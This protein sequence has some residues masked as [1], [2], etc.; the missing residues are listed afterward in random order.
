MLNSLAR[1]I[2][3]LLM[4]VRTMNPNCLSV[5]SA[6]GPS[7]AMSSRLSMIKFIPL[8]LRPGCR[9]LAFLG[10]LATLEDV[11]LFGGMAAEGWSAE[12]PG[13]PGLQTAGGRPLQSN[14]CW[15]AK[16]TR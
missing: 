13:C 14:V 4:A 15:V 5:R 16:H 3:I 7:V 2:A 8:R 12:L 6:K 9:V 1:P 10:L 11:F